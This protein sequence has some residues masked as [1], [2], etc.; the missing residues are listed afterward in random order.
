VN[1]HEVA[2]WANICASDGLE[3]PDRELVRS[4]LGSLARFLPEGFVTTRKG[5]ML[6]LVAEMVE[7]DATS[8]QAAVAL[9]HLLGTTLGEDGGD[10]T[11]RIVGQVIQR[12]RDDEKYRR[13]LGEVW[14]WRDGTIACLLEMSE[15]FLGECSEDN[16]EDL[17][18]LFEAATE[19]TERNSHFRT[20]NFPKAI[21]AALK[22][23]IRPEWIGEDSEARSTLFGQAGLLITRFP[24]KF[25]TLEA[26]LRIDRENFDGDVDV[27]DS[28]ATESGVNPAYGADVE[29]NG[30]PSTEEDA[31]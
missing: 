20:P 5:E 29:S 31:I 16:P 18:F 28:M 26:H 23:E 8:D 24:T 13:L 9:R 19:L 10:E 25:E 27:E 22:G 30:Q 6:H 2:S 11:K 4:K 12:F 1:A 15:D 21:V 7:T 14:G 17:V 3:E